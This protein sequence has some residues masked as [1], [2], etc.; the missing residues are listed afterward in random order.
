M[1]KVDFAID[2]KGKTKL[3]HVTLLKKYIRRFTVR[4]STFD[5]LSSSEVIEEVTYPNV[6]TNLCII[7]DSPDTDFLQIQ[8]YLL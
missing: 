2:V 1:N 4:L 7:E 5:G 6:A 3:F 8:S